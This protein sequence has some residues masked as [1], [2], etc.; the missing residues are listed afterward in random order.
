[1][2]PHQSLRAGRALIGAI[3]LLM[4]PGLGNAAAFGPAPEP[5]LASPAQ[6]APR[7]GGLDEGVFGLVDGSIDPVAHASFTVAGRAY[8]SSDFNL[9]TLAVF[10]L[11][12]IGHQEVCID[13]DAAQKPVGASASV[14]VCGDAIV[15]ATSWPFLTGSGELD[16]N[17]QT[18][19]R[20]GFIDNTLMGFDPFSV[21]GDPT[22]PNFL[23]ALKVAV[24]YK[25]PDD[26]IVATVAWTAPADPIVTA[27]LTAFECLTA[28][29]L[30]GGVVTFIQPANNWTYTFS[31][32]P[33]SSITPDF[34][35]GELA[36]VGVTAQ[37]GLEGSVSIVPA[38]IGGCPDALETMPPAIPAA[39]PTPSPMSSSTPIATESPSPSAVSSP[40]P[41]N[42]SPAPSLSASEPPT[43]GAIVANLETTGPGS[44]GNPASTVEATGP[45]IL[46]LLLAALLAA[47]G[48]GLF[49]Q[50]KS[51]DSRPVPAGADPSLAALLVPPAATP[52]IAL[53]DAGLTPRER[54]V[55]AMV[56]DGLTNREIGSA[57]FITESTAGV[58]VSNILGKLGVDSRTEAARY[59]LQAGIKPSGP[60][61]PLN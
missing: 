38:L 60:A 33:G 42:D 30:A 4:L 3:A 58:H 57:L 8:Q 61:G 51:R 20:M 9:V 37:R 59:A 39:T 36:G 23:S 34:E 13:E 27:S 53:E 19:E 17:G 35:P 32:T 49:W 43:A 7:C 41:S 14:D 15:G 1:V 24:D 21:Q 2:P 50:I 48:A 6:S 12:W 54:E 40:T 22:P 45:P 28:D 5:S 52:S 29:E 56:A 55:L 44:P 25:E 16:A 47:A 46:G 26:C 18:N 31:L 10:E 11:A